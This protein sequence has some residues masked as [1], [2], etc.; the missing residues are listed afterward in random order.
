MDISSG[1]PIKKLS[2]T[3]VSSIQIMIRKNI[4]PT[5]ENTMLLILTATPIAAYIMIFCLWPVP[6]GNYRWA[7]ALVDR[8]RGDRPWITLAVRDA[9]PGWLHLEKTL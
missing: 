6:A 1:F 8:L 3:A 2:G 9:A 7:V 4:L 5:M